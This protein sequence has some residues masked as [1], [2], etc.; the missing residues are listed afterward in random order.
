[1][2][3]EATMLCIDNSDFSRNSDYQPNRLDAQKDAIN[4]LAGI[5]SQENPE[6][7]IGLMSLAGVPRLLVTPTDDLGKFLNTL[8]RVSAGGVANI[9]NGLQKAHLALK[10][11]ENK[12]QRMRIIMFLGSPIHTANEELQLVAKKL[13]KCNVAVDIISFGNYSDNGDKLKSFISNVNKTNNSNLIE[14]IDTN[15]SNAVLNDSKLTNGSS[16]GFAASAVTSSLQHQGGAEQDAELE[17]A[18]R[19]SLE[20][21]RK[22]QE[23]QEIDHVTEENAASEDSLEDEEEDLLQ[24]ALFLSQNE[25]DT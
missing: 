7:S 14:V 23:Q 22:R 19:I 24:K 15:I 16:S 25:K 3:L 12:T 1:M 8:Y 5:K 6:N 17:L 11:R 21:E 10:H 13:K 2:V 9:L 20:E 4:I 18:L